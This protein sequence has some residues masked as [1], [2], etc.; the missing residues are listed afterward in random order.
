MQRQTFVKAKSEYPHADVSKQWWMRDTWTVQ[1]PD[2]TDTVW[3]Q[4]LLSSYDIQL[5]TKWGRHGSSSYFMPC[6]SA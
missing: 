5:T 2:H 3:F 1:K 6:I 4:I